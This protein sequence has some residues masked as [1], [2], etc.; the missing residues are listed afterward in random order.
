MTDPSCGD[1]ANLRLCDHLLQNQEFSSDPGGNGDDYELKRNERIARSEL[2]TLA[3]CHPGRR[4]QYIDSR[5]CVALQA[6]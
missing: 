2:Y 4:F 6:G 5:R 1:R 3:G